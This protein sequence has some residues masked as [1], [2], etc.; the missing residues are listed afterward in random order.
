MTLRMTNVKKIYLKNKLERKKKRKK[1]R[2]KQNALQLVNLPVSRLAVFIN[3]F[4]IRIR[5]GS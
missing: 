3:R 5:Q 2:K 4:L 1:E